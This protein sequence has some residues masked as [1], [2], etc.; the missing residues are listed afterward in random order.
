MLRLVRIGLVLVCAVS[1]YG[2][3]KIETK[4][5]DNSISRFNGNWQASGVTDAKRGEEK[6]CRYGDSAGLLS[7]QGTQVSG[8]LKDNS[9]YPYELTGTVDASGRISGAFTYKGYDAAT[10]EGTLTDS[11]GNGSFKDINGCPGTWKLT[12]A[13]AST[14]AR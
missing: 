10:F 5:P 3:N 9:G 1:I 14:A 7:I 11:Q 4:K 8:N 13:P 6:N 2:C 12:K